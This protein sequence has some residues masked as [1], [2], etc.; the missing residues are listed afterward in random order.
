MCILEIHAT[1]KMGT[2]MQALAH[3]MDTLKYNLETAIR[4]A[5]KRGDDDLVGKLSISLI[6][7]E[8]DR[9]QVW[10]IWQNQHVLDHEP[11]AHEV[12]PA[13]GAENSGVT[14]HFDN[15]GTSP[16]LQ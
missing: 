6:R 16:L 3:N 2:A 7:F 14:I 5:R 12:G 1:S 15:H 10:D 9:L 11:K 13:I 4:L 8:R